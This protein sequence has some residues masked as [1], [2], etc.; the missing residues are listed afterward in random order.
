M[1]YDQFLCEVYKLYITSITIIVL[2]VNI[3]TA[4]VFERERKKYFTP[5]LNNFHPHIHLLL[6]G[7]KMIL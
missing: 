4:F 7:K 2:A 1:K 3:A 6:A 5:F